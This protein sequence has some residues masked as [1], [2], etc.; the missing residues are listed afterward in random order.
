MHTYPAEC[1]PGHI[2]DRPRNVAS[3]P[4]YHILVGWAD[5]D[6]NAGRSSGDGQGPCGGVG[7]N[8]VRPPLYQ[9]CSKPGKQVE[10]VLGEA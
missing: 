2:G 1:N 9:L 8:D 7:M 5:D 3:E 10:M 4:L 6:G